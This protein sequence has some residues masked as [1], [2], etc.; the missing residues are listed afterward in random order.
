M[1]W[2]CRLPETGILAL[3]SM[4]SVKTEVRVNGPALS[5]AGF[6][7]TFIARYWVTIEVQGPRR[8]VRHHRAHEG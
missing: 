6:Q 8:R 7:V 5:L 4:S 2:G 1:P 3:L